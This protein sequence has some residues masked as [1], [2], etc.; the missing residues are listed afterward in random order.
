MNTISISRRKFAQLLGAGAVC[1]DCVASKSD[2]MCPARN[3]YRFIAI[4]KDGYAHP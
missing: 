3:G 4:E 2:R 1:A